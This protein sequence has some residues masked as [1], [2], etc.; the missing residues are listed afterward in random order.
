MTGI[1]LHLAGRGLEFQH[2]GG[3]PLR[4]DAANASGRLTHEAAEAEI[5]AV[6]A[7]DYG[8]YW[9]L[10]HLLQHLQQRLEPS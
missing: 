9:A 10:V 8:V 7:E 4:I 6:L 3:V 5:L 1:S 2:T